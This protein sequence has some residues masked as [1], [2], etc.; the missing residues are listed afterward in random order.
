MEEDE[1]SGNM[2]KKKHTRFRKKFKHETK[3]CSVIIKKIVVYQNDIDPLL[4]KGNKE[5]DEVIKKNKCLND[6]EIPRCSERKSKP[7]KCILQFRETLKRKRE[8]TDMFPNSKMKNG[9]RPAE[10]VQ[11][12][13][14][15]DKKVLAFETKLCSV[16]MKKDHVSVGD[17]QAATKDGEGK[18]GKREIWRDNHSQNLSAFEEELRKRFYSEQN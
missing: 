15:Y 8:T 5:I 13:D 18:K 7:T 4:K 16:N 1:R 11:E 9:E 6:Q 17:I 12:Q 2:L 10:H 14:A 3:R